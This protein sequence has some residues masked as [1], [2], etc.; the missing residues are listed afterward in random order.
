MKRITDS[1]THRESKPTLATNES[2]GETST[3]NNIFVFN[4]THNRLITKHHTFKKNV[5]NDLLL[6]N[7]D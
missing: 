7:R 5:Q 3:R 2:V 1:S 4:T 6:E